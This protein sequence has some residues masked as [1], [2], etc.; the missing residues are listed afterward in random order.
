MKHHPV[1]LDCQRTGHGVFHAPA[2]RACAD[3][4]LIGCQSLM[5]PISWEKSQA[6]TVIFFK[7]S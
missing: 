5:S 1:V 7:Q 2:G 6:I 3:R 4:R